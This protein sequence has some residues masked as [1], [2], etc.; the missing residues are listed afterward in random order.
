MVTY[1]KSQIGK[2]YVSLV[3][4]QFRSSKHHIPLYDYDLL[5]G[6]RFE[7]VFRLVF[8]FFSLALRSEQTKHKHMFRQNVILSWLFGLVRCRCRCRWV[9]RS[10]GRSVWLPL[11]LREENAEL[12]R[13]KQFERA[14]EPRSLC[15]TLSNW[16]LFTHCMCAVLCAPL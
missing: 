10:V 15:M 5:F 8:F 1:I 12:K 7:S 13:S 6:T 4:C 16:Y 11:S 3:A 9:G 2:V 14:L